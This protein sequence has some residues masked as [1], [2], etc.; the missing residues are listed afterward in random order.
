MIIDSPENRPLAQYPRN[1]IKAAVKQMQDSGIADTMYILPEFEFYLFDEV[2][3]GVDGSYIGAS[4]D[5]KQSYWNSTVEGKGVG[6]TVSFGGLLG[7]APIINVNPYSCEK[8][9][10]RGGRI[11]APIH[12]LKN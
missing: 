3:W 1:I 2:T 5:A 8:F 12:S 4:V 7:Y 11:P 6:E 10:A 9:I